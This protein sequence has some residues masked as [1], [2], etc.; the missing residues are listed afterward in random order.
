MVPTCQVFCLLAAGSIVSGPVVRRFIHL[1]LVSASGVFH[2]DLCNG[3][4][5]GTLPPSAWLQPRGIL[6]AIPLGSQN[7]HLSGIQKRTPRMP[8]PPLLMSS[9]FFLFPT[10]D[11]QAPPAFWPLTVCPSVGDAH[12]QMS[13]DLL[14]ASFLSRLRHHV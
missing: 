3:L 2:P 10:R 5:H 8:P 1:A 7:L 14:N 12:L 4:Q 6:V 11:I 13:Y 9:N